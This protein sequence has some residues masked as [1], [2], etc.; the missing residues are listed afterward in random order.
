MRLYD[1]A[2]STA[3]SSLSPVLGRYF[4]LEWERGAG[5]YL[6]DTAGRSYLDF[7]CGI[8]VTALGHGHPRVNAAI[9]EQVDRLLHTSN[10]LGYLDPVSRLADAL[11]ATLPASIDSVFLA[12]SGTEVVEAALKLARR[13]T[14]RPG[15]VAFQGAFHGRTYGS[16]SVTSS[17][18]GYRTGHEPLLPA[19]HISPFPAQR[20]AE[21][22]EAAAMIALD[23]LRAAFADGL[24]PASVGSIIVEPIQ[25]EGGFN[26]AGRS[27]LQ[28]LRAIADEIGAL[29][30]VDEIQTGLGRTGRMWAFEAAGIVPDVVTIGKAIANGLPLAAMAS[31]RELQARWGRGA[32][33]STF[34]GNPVACAAGLAVLATIEEEGLVANSRDRGQRLLDD[35]R[36]VAAADSRV[37]DVR[38]AG[39][40]V[41]VELWDPATL[42]PAG[43]L[44]NAVIAGCAEEGLLLLTCG[45]NHEVVRWLPPIDVTDPEVDGA[46][47]TFS[48]VLARL[49]V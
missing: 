12:N 48:K 34:G 13:V 39:L 31:S 35:L 33:G 40:M 49:T 8:A 45:T 26:V 25:G 18:P 24:D 38:G 7:A 17:N 47:E 44:A 41:G 16:L 9:H 37:A 22:V 4:E 19:V 42:A 14:G 30:V 21:G 32:H 43:D 10:G 3:G 5:H 23:A 36:A 20:H 29:L 11:T 46:V 15:I 6:V 28:G 27:F 2:M 1:D